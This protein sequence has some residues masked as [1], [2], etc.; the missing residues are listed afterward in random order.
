MNARFGSWT[1][2]GVKNKREGWTAVVTRPEN[3]P[4]CD[5]AE[6]G[7]GG[8]VGVFLDVADQLPHRISVALVK[9]VQ[10]RT[11]QCSVTIPKGKGTKL[12]EWL[13][14]FYLGF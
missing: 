7:H 1:P 3:E 4:V 2:E 8:G 6:Y 10:L 13:G 5:L 14:V 9:Q 12:T 11:K